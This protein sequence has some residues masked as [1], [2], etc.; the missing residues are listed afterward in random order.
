VK[1]I[2]MMGYDLDVAELAA[3]KV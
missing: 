3:L 2:V 1:R